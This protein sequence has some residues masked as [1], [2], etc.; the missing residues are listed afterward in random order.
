LEQKIK[1]VSRLGIMNSIPCFRNLMMT[2]ALSFCA[3]QF[4][5]QAAPKPA[6]VVASRPPIDMVFAIDCSGS[7]GG[8]IETAKQKVWDIV[9]EVARAK[10]SPKLRIGL[11]GYGNGNSTWRKFDLSDDLDTVY[12]NLMTFKDEGWASEYV[13][14]ALSKSLKEMSWSKANGSHTALRVIYVLG[15]ETAEQGPISYKTSA[16]QALKADIFVNAIYCGNSGGQDTWQQMATLGG[17]KYLEIAADGGSVVI[18]TPYDKPIAELN[19]K[20]NGTYLGYGVRGRAGA[21]NQ[22]AQDANAEAAGGSYAN[23]ARAV[24]KSSNQYNNSAWDLV[25]KSKEKNFDLRKIPTEELPEAMKKMTPDQQ[26]TYL[27][28]KSTERTSLQK[29]IQDLGTKRNTFLRNEMKKKGNANSLD[30]ALLS[31]V[32]SQATKN[33]FKFSDK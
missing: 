11:L 2:L 24:A 29:Q 21:A 25:D 10:P 4:P 18:P 17:G 27:E 28:K 23:A 15:N 26:K 9:N 19:T 7:M 14:Q 13:G 1:R 5:V 33:G 20:L 30:T 8:V 32:R 12:G 22:V 16:P 3:T 6:K 31:L